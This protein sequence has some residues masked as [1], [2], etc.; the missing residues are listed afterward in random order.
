V[1]WVIQRYGKW[2]LIISDRSHTTSYRSA[3]VSIAVCLPFLRYLTF[4]N[5][6]IMKSKL[7]VTY[8][9]NLCT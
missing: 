9:A 7:W 2:H 3:I 6:V 1:G 8:R 4:K 5:I